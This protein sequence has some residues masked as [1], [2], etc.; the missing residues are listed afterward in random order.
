VLLA[1]GTADS[2]AEGLSRGAAEVGVDEGAAAL[3]MAAGAD[4]TGAA[5]EG[6][7]GLVAHK[8][9][10]MSAPGWQASELISSL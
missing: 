10:W 8:Y 1:S 2:E 4:E 9:M 5:P 6:P 3:E 7:F